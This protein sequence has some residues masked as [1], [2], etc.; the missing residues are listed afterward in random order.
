MLT[1]SATTHALLRRAGWSET[2]RV[3][4]GPYVAALRTEGYPVHPIVVEFLERFGSLTVVH[5]H[6][7]VRNSDDR[8][9]FD[10]ARAVSR[11][12]PENV[13]VDSERVGTPLCVIGEAYCGY[14]AL[15]MDSAGKVYASLDDLLIHIGDSGPDA[16]EALCTGRS[17]TELP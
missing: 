15:L 3:D 7:K 5:P 17:T 11:A 1:F 14:M 8:F 9:H 4:T 10:V 16:I 2:R 6:H 13:E 12:D